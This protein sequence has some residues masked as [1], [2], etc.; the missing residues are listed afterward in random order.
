MTSAGND[1]IALNYIDKIRTKQERFYS[2]FL[3]P[4]E[5]NLYSAGNFS[6]LTFEN[7]VWLLWSVKESVYKFCKR[8]SARLAF[9]PGKIISQSLQA[10]LKSNFHCF[11]TGDIENTFL[12]K[13]ECWSCTVSA[14]TG[15][16][17]SRSKVYD[18]VIYTVVN[19]TDNFENIWWGIKYIDSCD[20]A[21]Q[22]ESVRHFA[23]EKIKAIY[24]NTRL[25]IA[26]SPVGYPVLIVNETEVNLPV[27][28]THHNHF[29]G[30]A[31]KLA[32]ETLCRS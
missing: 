17:Y 6:G 15:D 26:K 3:S 8:N 18:E 28:F 10:P 21:H 30:Y 27:S 14:E 16:Y 9:S 11:G 23:L 22:S 20:A 4:A 29:I 24:P 7:F 19:D 2:K 32:G 25:D 13:D 1:I 31:L 5:V 12:I